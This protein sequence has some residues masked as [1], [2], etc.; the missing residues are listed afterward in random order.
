MTV[1]ATARPVPYERP[2]V[3]PVNFGSGTALP[4]ETLDLVARASL[5]RAESDALSERAAQI[6]E[7]AIREAYLKLAERFVMLAAGLEAEALTRG[8]GD[9]QTTAL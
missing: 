3:I 7:A 8:T 2:E 5:F 6:G 9:A 4:R 1:V